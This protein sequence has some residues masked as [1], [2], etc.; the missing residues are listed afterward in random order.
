MEGSTEKP[1]TKATPRRQQKR[2]AKVEAWRG[3]R[4]RSMMRTLM[5]A[6][7]PATTSRMIKLKLGHCKQKVVKGHRLEKEGVSSSTFWRLNELPGWRS[8]C[9]VVKI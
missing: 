2:K 8:F 5:L 6:G 1:V 7:R 9:A 3:K 4:G